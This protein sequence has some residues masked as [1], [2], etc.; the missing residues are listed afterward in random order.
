MAL[1]TAQN[2]GSAAGTAVV[3]SAANASDT[4]KPVD[5]RAKIWVKNDSAGATTVTITTNKSIAGLALPNR[6]VSVAAGAIKA[7]PLFK[8]LYADAATG[9]ITIATSP[10]TTISTAIVTE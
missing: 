5:D 10:V 8:D 7:V 1:L 6:V 2:I 3:F 4:F 9:L